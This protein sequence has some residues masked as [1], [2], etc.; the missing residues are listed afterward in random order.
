MAVCTTVAVGTPGKAAFA[1]PTNLV[2]AEFS[3]AAAGVLLTAVVAGTGAE[4]LL[5]AVEVATAGLV[6]GARA[7]ALLTT[8]A[9]LEIKVGLTAA[10]VAEDTDTE[11]MPTAPTGAV[12]EPAVALLG[13]EA[14]PLLLV[15]VPVP[16]CEPQPLRPRATA[17]DAMARAERCRVM[18][19]TIL[20]AR[21]IV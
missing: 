16:V 15:P 6:V 2:C 13:L 12:L 21:T 20:C 8:T 18:I 17:I 7:D 4:L 19:L 10:L 1:R 5:D 11:L 9:L 14:V 3:P